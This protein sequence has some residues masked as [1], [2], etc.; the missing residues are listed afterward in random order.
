MKVLIIDPDKVGLDLALC[1]QD[2]GHKV[3][4]WLSA[5][6]GACRSQ[7]G[8]GLVERVEEW[9][10]SMRW[11]DLII[12]TDCSKYQAALR[13]F[14]NRGFPIFGANEETSELE[15]DRAKGQEILEAHGIETL[16][17]V[18]FSNFD[19]AIAFAKKADR[20]YVVKPWGGTSDKAL[21]YVSS[22]PA[23]LVFKLERWKQEGLK[24]DFMLQEKCEGIEMAASGWFGPGGWSEPIEEC[25]EEKKLMN[26]GLGQNTGEMGC[27]DDATEV[28]TYRGWKLWEEVTEEDQLATL[29]GGQLRFEKPSKI[30][31]Y[32][33]TGP[34]I[35]WHNQTLDICVTPNHQ[36]YVNSQF[37]ARK[38]VENFKFVLAEDCTQA[39]YALQRTAVWEGRPVSEFSVE[40]YNYTRGGKQDDFIFNAEAWARFLGF[41]IA[42]GWSSDGQVC[43]AQ[44]H[45]EKA[46]KAESLI[47]DLKIPYSRK[48]NYFVFNNPA[49]A[50]HLKP[51]GRSWEK[52]VPQYIKDSPKEII[53]AFLQGYALGDGH[54]F[55][56]GYRIFYTCNERLAGDVQELLLK[57]GRIGIVKCRDRR[58]RSNTAPDGHEIIA[59]RLSY[60]V[61]ERVEK[62][63]SWLDKRDRAIINYSGKVYCATVSSHTLFVRRNGKPLWCGNTTVRLTK[64]SK[65]FDKVLKP[66]TKYLHACSYVGDIDVNCIIDTAGRPWPL[67]FTTRLGWPDWNI[68]SRLHEGDPV[69]WMLDL[70]GG[71]DTLRVRYECAVG[72]VMAHGDFPY[73]H[74]AYECGCGF[75]ITG[76]PRERSALALQAVAEGNAPVEVGGQVKT[77]RTL[78]TAGDYVAV[79]VGC[80]PTVTA[81]QKSAYRVAWGVKWPSNR[82]FRTDISK[83]LKKELPLLQEHGYAMGLNYV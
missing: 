52:W 58:E 39:Q 29:Q 50:Q 32:D 77:M 59:K 53:E 12:L 22:G 27:Y 5:E 76:V 71:K 43:V 82:M 67:E 4:L 66:L 64:K 81:A 73:D 47:R 31:V 69:E 21:T 65:L 7:V 55:A 2:A 20:A 1:A 38:G 35:Y 62:S 17:Y 72:V 68:R 70:L 28:L 33:Y 75:P 46:T 23:D 51:L 36:M 10:P 25:W 40:G 24:G 42:E 30:V 80:G 37:D 3:R 41:Y 14:F 56:K 60:E 11:A 57:I 48:E 79:A 83:R 34:M 74:E 45:H 63:R 16:P 15:L 18:T 44:S 19:K 49:L 26:D 78:V 8:D 61:L 6:R 13:P 9:Q 54:T